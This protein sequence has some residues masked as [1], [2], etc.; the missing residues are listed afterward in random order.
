[1]FKRRRPVKLYLFC[2]LMF[3]FVMG[4]FLLF[5]LSIRPTIVEIAEARAVQ[6]ATEA[7]NSSVQE[8][9]MEN[10]MAYQDFVQLHKDTNGRIVL[11]QANTIKVN[12]FAADVTLAIQKTLQDLEGQ[13]F[14]IP[15]GQVTGS[16]ILAAL[17]PG[18][19]VNIIPV[20]TVRV[21]VEDKF[22]QAG[23][24]QTRHRIYLGFDTRV[25]I[26]V[27]TLHSEARVATRV[28]LTESIIVGDVPATYVSLSDG[29]FGSG[30]IK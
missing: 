15:L 26:V 23:I 13:S 10:N 11:M 6:V 30:I 28:P 25:R 14:S 17:G 18:I 16:R 27:P 19:K 21:D 9:V 24:N 22:E 7:V 20:G 2:I 12:Q 8:K 3:L 29:L 5:E 4:V 1:M